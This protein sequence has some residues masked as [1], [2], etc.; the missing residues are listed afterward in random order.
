MWELDHKKGWGPKNWCLWIVVLE[1]ILESSLDCK[2]IKLVNPKGNQL[3]YSLEGL[4]L[5]LKLQ[6]F[7]HLTHKAN[8]LGKNLITGNNW[9]Q[10]EKV[11]ENEMN[12]L[13]GHESEQTL[14]D[15]EGQ[16]SL[17]CCPWNSKESDTTE[18]WNNSNNLGSEYMVLD[19]VSFYVLLFSQSKTKISKS[20]LPIHLLDSHRGHVF[21]KELRGKCGLSFCD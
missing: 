10:K 17:A 9:R 4:M 3:E 20:N 5:K 6:Y 2:E 1:K 18:R 16:G 15:G 7:G 8:S 12:W 19:P 21:R 13:N 11:A 14:G